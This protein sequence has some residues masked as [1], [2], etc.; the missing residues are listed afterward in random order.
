MERVSNI[1]SHERP[2]NSNYFPALDGLR[3]VAFLMVFFT[4]YSGLPWGFTGVNAFFVLSGFLITGILFDTRDEPRRV[5]NFYVRRTLRIFP[6]YY[7][8]ILLVVLSY[9]LLH[10]RWNWYWLVW[11]A[12][13]GNFAW[14]C[15]PFLHGPQLAMLADA[16]PFSEA[17]QGVRLFFGHFWSLCVEEQF[18][19]FWPW[20]VFSIKDRVKLMR[21]CVAFLLICPILRVLGDATFPPLLLDARMTAKA[22][23]LCIDALLLGGF[24]AL[25]RRGRLARPMLAAARF[26]FPLLSGAILLWLVAYV[27]SPTRP[28]SLHLSIVG[29]YVGSQ[30]G[31]LFIR[32]CD[33]HG[34]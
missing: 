1:T 19:L 18:Y 15:Y 33:A 13:L 20:I 8:V 22:T 34:A 11:P 24:I 21:I 17:H 29:L 25:G 16:Q 3:A 30:P 9:P 28:A 7:G 31:G 32:M 26:C 12:Y 5:H 14:F 4:H 23:P 6:L 27:L 2:A 10:W